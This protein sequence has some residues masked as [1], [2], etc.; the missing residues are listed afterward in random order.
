M[1]KVNDGS[2]SRTKEGKDEKGDT[3]ESVHGLYE[4]RELTRNAYKSG[5]FPIKSTQ[6]KRRFK[7]LTLK[8]MF[9]RFS[10][11]HAQ[12][13]ADNTSENILNEIRQLIYSLYQ[14]KEITKD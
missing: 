9:Q 13:K 11:A 8:Q 12:V 14:A 4:G 2:R 10:I 3:C 1:V 6:G 5:I 7:I